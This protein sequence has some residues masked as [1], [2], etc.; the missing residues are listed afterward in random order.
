M[1]RMK[2][3]V[4]TFTGKDAKLLQ[5][6]ADIAKVTKR[7]YL[8][9]ALQLFGQATLNGR[10]TQSSGTTKTITRSYGKRKKK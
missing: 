6:A 5:E 7:Q 8:L 1:I 3:R 4:V 9:S 2:G 10:N